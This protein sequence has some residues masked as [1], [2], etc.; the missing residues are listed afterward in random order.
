MSLPLR[1]PPSLGLA[2][3]GLVVVAC[4][5]SDATPPEPWIDPGTP[6]QFLA[7]ELIPRLELRIDPADVARLEHAPRTY[8]PATILFGG[9][10]FGPVGVRLKGQNSFLPFSQK[11]SLRINVN[12]YIPDATFYG[13]TDLTL[14]NMKSDP[15]MMHEKLA[16]RVAR[17]AGLIASRA[18]HLE[19][20]INGQPYGLYTNLETVKRALFPDPKGSLFE[21]TDVD[22]TPDLTDRYE[23]E[24]GPDDRGLIDGL[25]QALT[26]PSPEAALA[27]AGQFIDLSH[28]QK[29]WAME[30][31]VAQ[32]DAFPYSM[33]G[34]D[35]FVYADPATHKLQLVPWG[36]DETFLS[37]E[38]PPLQVT[39]KLATVCKASP[40][41]QQGYVD[42]VWALLAK[43]EQLGL[44][45]ERVRVQ[46]EIAPLVAADPRKPYTDAE[47][48]EYQTQL[49]YFI[50]GRRTI[51]TRDF[52]PPSAP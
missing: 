26:N 38:Y 40:A 11:P 10:E 30:T 46:E 27:A 28:F 37:A 13:L 17:E 7:Y 43:T 31:I 6:E 29:F 52:P 44:E 33:P 32:Y 18:N 9:G 41:C 49:G 47:I 50:R 45:A 48:A 4:T 1:I 51:L 14:N 36:M 21:A 3:N 25:A 35:Y 24:A 42:E 16:Y 15:S 20:T 23:L 22:F 12:E 8:V 2:L 19:L 39:S 5:M 34:D